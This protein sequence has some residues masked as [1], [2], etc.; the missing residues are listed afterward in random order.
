MKIW[1]SGT[2]AYTHKMTMYNTGMKKVNG[3]VNIKV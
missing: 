2:D 1:R 3:C